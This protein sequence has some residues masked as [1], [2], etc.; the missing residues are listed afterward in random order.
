MYNVVHLMDC[1]EY[2]ATVPD[3]FFD[4]AIVD[5]PYGIKASKKIKYHK[6]ALTK[7]KKKNWDNI[8]PDKKY[9][10]ELFRISKYQIIWGANYF[11]KYLPPAKNWIVWDKKQPRG[12][13]LSMHELAY[14]NIEKIQAMIIRLYNGA[15]RC[16]NNPEKAKKYIR[17]HPTQKPIALYKWLLQNYAKP[18]WKIVD[19]HVGSGSIRIACHDLGFWFEGCEIDPDY[20]RDQ[21]NRFQNH[22]AQPE[23]IDKQEIQAAIFEQGKL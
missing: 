10:Q 8:I 2:M 6:N 9:F 22:I 11:T 15:N 4:L 21:E 18:G 5:P 14:C 17:I 12:I 7:Y 13:S 3:K 23:L 16:S 20:W 19:T 1:M